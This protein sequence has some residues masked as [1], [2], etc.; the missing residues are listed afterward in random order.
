MQSYFP[1]SCPILLFFW[2]KCISNAIQKQRANE[3]L[4]KHFTVSIGVL[5]N[6]VP[7]LAHKNL[8]FSF[9]LLTKTA[10]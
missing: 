2:G 1:S 4:L 10:G 8:K 5:Y 7:S 3:H 9:V 6:V